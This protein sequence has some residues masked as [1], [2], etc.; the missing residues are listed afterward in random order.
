MFAEVA[1][2]LQ[3]FFQAAVGH[4]SMMEGAIAL[5]AQHTE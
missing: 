4:G 2:N 3:R 5:L 1:D